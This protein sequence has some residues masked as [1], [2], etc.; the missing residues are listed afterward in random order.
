MDRNIVYPGSI[1][2]DTDLLNTNQNV[3]IALGFLAQAVLGTNAVADG[4]ACSPTVPASLSVTVGAGSMTLL[5]PVDTSPYGSVAADAADA[6]V[7]MG[8]N[9][10][11]SSFAITPPASSG[12]SIVYIIEAAFSEADVN[13]VVLPYYNASNP[14]QSFS[15]PGNSGNAQNT[16][17]AQRVQ[18]QLKAGIPA[19]TGTQVAPPTDSG[20]IGLYQ[21]TV[22]FGQT[23][24]T[25]ANIAAMMGAPFIPWKLPSLSPGVAA[26]VQSFTANG[27]FTVPPGVRQVEVEVWGAGSGSFASVAG[28]PSGGGAG[29]GYAKKL[30]TGL[31]S[32]QAITV[33]VGAGG[34][35]GTTT[36][37]LATGG[38]TSSFGTFVSATGGSVYYL[39]TP[40]APTAGA[41][42]S[43]MGF[44]GDVNFQGSPGQSGV[45]N[46]GGLGG[47]APIGGSQSSSG[48]G[49]MGNFP[50]GGASGAGT[51]SS[52][53][54]AFNGGAGAS[55]LIVV[56][57]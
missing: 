2:L 50:G 51:G 45:A 24:I 41:T 9:L 14:A 39:A 53:N 8:I 26:G 28:L 16:L 25:A 56:R 42:P 47:S 36:G 46:Q 7:K 57:W 43:G 3:M 13:P 38:A 40:A 49:V 54:T 32:G 17:R 55:G 10:T 15:G 21:I 31:T 22:A 27:V 33:T 48:A 19:A 12:Q 20:W 6:I 23:A 11:P 4:L 34:V 5:G 30:V 52:G 1:P 37:S 18:L 44:N 35:A 29:G